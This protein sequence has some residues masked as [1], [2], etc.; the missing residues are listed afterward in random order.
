MLVSLWGFLFVYCL[1]ISS[2]HFHWGFFFLLTCRSSLY[3]LLLVLDIAKY[4]L[5]VCQLSVNFV[6]G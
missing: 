5:P 2:A 6:D 4:L 3:T 1:F